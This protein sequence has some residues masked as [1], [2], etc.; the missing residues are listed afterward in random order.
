MG[1]TKERV[2]VEQS[3]HSLDFSQ[4]LDTFF[5]F[6]QVKAASPSKDL[7]WYETVMSRAVPGQGLLTRSQKTTL[8]RRFECEQTAAGPP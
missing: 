7:V 5:L 4:L 2:K 1:Q 8:T 3:P 6:H